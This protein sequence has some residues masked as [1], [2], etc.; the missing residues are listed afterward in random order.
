MATDASLSIALTIDPIDV[1]G[2]LVDSSNN[3]LVADLVVS[4]ETRRVVYKPAA[5]E[6][7][8][9]DFPD[10][11]LGR[12]EV[13]AYHLSAF[14]GWDQI[15]MT[16]WRDDGPAGPGMCQLWIDGG[17][18]DDY[19]S[20]FAPTTV[21]TGWLAILQGVDSAGSEVV[22]AHADDV[23]LQRLAIFDHL[24]NNAD[25]KAGHLIVATDEETPRLWAIDHGLTFHT[26]PKLRTVLW[27]FA[28]RELPPSIAKDIASFLNRFD[29]F[30]RSVSAHLTDE[31][32][33][34]VNTRAR[35]LIERGCFPVPR[36]DGPAVP[37]PIF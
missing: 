34:G 26:E 37:W 14:L 22:L 21:P 28:D 24:A 20:L 9:W 29:G 1:V 6:R 27:G 19:I 7:P 13:A 31:C 17:T 4:G 35:E 16:V 11:E 2:R 5:G 15:P 10:G 36:D 32:L 25:R 8:L 23:A 3:A 30:A 33:A 18:P 12:R